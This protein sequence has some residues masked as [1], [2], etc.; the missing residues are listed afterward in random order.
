M[1]QTKVG[2]S[3]Q[4]QTMIEKH[5]SEEA[6][7]QFMRSIASKGGSRK[8]PKGFARMDKEKVRQAGLKGG[9][10]SKRGSKQA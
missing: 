1:A 2:I 10:I 3:K 5:G 4:R 8:V 6:W 7:T 9:A